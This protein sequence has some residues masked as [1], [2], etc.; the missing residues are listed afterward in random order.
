MS[1]EG[2]KS[3]GVLVQWKVCI[4]QLLTSVDVNILPQSLILLQVLQ[5]VLVLSEDRKESY[6]DKPCTTLQRK[7]YSQD[8]WPSWHI[9]RL[10]TNQQNNA[11][12]LGTITGMLSVFPYSVPETSVQKTNFPHSRKMYLR[13]KLV[14]IL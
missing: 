14:F 13:I 4:I 7:T 6:K 3:L 1:T 8:T 9:V 10:F 2:L 5:E 11:M 12:S